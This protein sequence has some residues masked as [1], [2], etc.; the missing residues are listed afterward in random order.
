MKVQS[1]TLSAVV[2][3]VVVTAVVVKTEA[4]DR[5]NKMRVKRVLAGNFEITKELKELLSICFNC[6]FVSSAFQ[7]TVAVLCCYFTARLQ[8]QLWTCE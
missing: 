3:F 8:E 2:L 7:I 5:G 4:S 1:G 6:S